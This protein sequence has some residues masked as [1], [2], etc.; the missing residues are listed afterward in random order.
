M[1]IRPLG[2]IGKI[3]RTLPVPTASYLGFPSSTQVD[4]DCLRM[5]KGYG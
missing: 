4:L 3:M 2:H 5:R 1:T